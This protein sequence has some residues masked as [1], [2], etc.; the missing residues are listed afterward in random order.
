VPE[1]PDVEGHRRALARSL[2]GRCVTSVTVSDAGILRNV[3]AASLRRRLVGHRF[4][5]PRRHGKWLILPTDGPILVVHN[6]MTGRPSVVAADSELERFTRLR[7]ALDRGE[8]RYT[9]MRKLR[10]IWLVADDDALARVIGPSGPDALEL[11]LESFREILAG[12]RGAVKPTLMDQTVLAGLGN[13]LTDEICWRAH[14][15]PG[16]PLPDLDLTEIRDLHTAMRQVL[17]TSVRHGCVP[18]LRGWLTRVRD[19]PEPRCPRCGAALRR[20][21]IGGRT[22]LWCPRDQ[23]R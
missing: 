12:R 16:R 2:A 19:R 10:G 18:S 4:T 9:D 21:R 17:R 5:A 1:L 6:G 11:D 22:S 23:S 20:A 15:R 3:S 7:V 13:L 14:I 8:L